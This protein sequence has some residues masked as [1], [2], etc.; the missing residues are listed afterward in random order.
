MH[1]E[2]PSR[3]KLR[4]ILELSAVLLGVLIALATD[5]WWLGDDWA[6][7]SGFLGCANRRLAA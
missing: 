6:V 2:P 1:G 5:A 3:S 7:K 4:P